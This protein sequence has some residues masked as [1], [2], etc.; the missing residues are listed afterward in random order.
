MKQQIKE[1][2]NEIKNIDAE[3]RT[4]L[5]NNER[6]GFKPYYYEASYFLKIIMKL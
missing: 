2:E 6:K 4:L 3:L 5:R 1:L